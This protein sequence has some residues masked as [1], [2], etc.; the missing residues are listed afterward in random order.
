MTL[1]GN[2]ANNTAGSGIVNTL[3][4][5]DLKVDHVYIMYFA[6][7]GLKIAR[8]W[9]M[10]VYESPIENNGKSG[11]YATGGSEASVI[12]CFLD[13]NGEYGIYA[14]GAYRWDIIGTSVYRSGYHGAWLNGEEFVWVGGRVLGN[15]FGNAGVYDGIFLGVAANRSIISGVVFDGKAPDDVK[16]Q[17]Y[18]INIPYS[19]TENVR[20]NGC[21]FF[22]HVTAGINDAGTRT[23][24]NGIGRG[25]YGVGGTP[26][27]GDWEVG[28]I[29]RNTDDNTLWIKCADGVMRQLA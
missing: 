19:G 18:G 24:I 25:A 12:G 27:A 8:A 2:K 3:N 26:T 1:Y 15:S 22:N 29:V 20:I 6:E 11:I 4:S 23:R 10:R 7:H 28:D 14:V 9:G 16:Y 21:S 5:Q 13:K 17:R